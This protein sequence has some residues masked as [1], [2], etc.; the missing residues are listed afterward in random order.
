MPNYGIIKQT[1]HKIDK[2]P[3]GDYP[4]CCHDSIG[5]M[6]PLGEFLNAVR[7]VEWAKEKGGHKNATGCGH[8]SAEAAY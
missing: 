4:H 5:N 3:D 1:V 2:R 7:A 6:T 8:C